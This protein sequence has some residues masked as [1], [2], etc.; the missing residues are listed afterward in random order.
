VKQFL[1]LLIGGLLLAGALSS[2]IHL[3]ADGGP[4]PQCPPNTPA[5]KP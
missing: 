1:L 2:P 3:N 5:C 4:G